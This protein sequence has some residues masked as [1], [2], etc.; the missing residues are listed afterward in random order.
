MRGRIDGGSTF[1]VFELV[2]GTDCPGEGWA[3]VDHDS[4][5]CLKNAVADDREP[6]LQPL[7]PEGLLV[8][9]SSTPGRGP[10]GRATCWSR[11]RATRASSP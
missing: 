7:I 2:S 3:R 8:P 1:S 5:A 10:I 9:P 4:Y 11:C 6:L